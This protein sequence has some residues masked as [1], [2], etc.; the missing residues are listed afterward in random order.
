MFPYLLG[1]AKKWVNILAL[2]AWGAAYSFLKALCLS[3]NLYYI[4]NN[5]QTLVSGKLGQSLGVFLPQ[6]NMHGRD[7]ILPLTRLAESAQIGRTMLIWGL[8]Y[9]SIK[10][11]EMTCLLASYTLKIE[12]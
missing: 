5:C 10:R 4:G 1:Q 6:Q 9:N 12:D 11:L 7:Q 3:I 8:L 2:N